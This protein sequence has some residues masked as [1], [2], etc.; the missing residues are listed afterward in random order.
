M[1]FSLGLARMIP[2]HVW[3]TGLPIKAEVGA[4]FSTLSCILLQPGTF[5]EFIEVSL[6]PS[7]VVST[8]RRGLPTWNNWLFHPQRLA[9]YSDWT[10]VSIQM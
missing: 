7:L 10:S 6:P 5:V 2:I 3:N 4:H 8:C 9:I 1:G